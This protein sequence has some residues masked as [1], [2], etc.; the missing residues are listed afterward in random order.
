MTALPEHFSAAARSAP[1]V[2][3]A[4]RD[5]VLSG[6]LGIPKTLP[7]KLFYDATGAALFASSGPIRATR[8]ARLSPST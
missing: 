4:L 7:P 3:D 1:G 8:A 2:H 6:L 5:E